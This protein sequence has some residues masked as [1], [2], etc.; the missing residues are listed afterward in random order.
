M[1]NYRVRVQTGEAAANG[2]IHLDC[3]VQKETSPDVWELI[4]LG[5]RTLVLDGEAVLAI[6]EGSGTDGHKLA[7]L[8]NLFKQEVL[9]WGVDKSD[10]AYNQLFALLPE[11]WPV[12]V[13][14]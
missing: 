14:L 12:T 2:D 8:A 11:G 4:P 3:H 13:S 5:H 1:A 7:A 10:D 9:A 6:T